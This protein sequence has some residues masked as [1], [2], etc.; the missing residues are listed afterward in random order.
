MTAVT[1]RGTFKKD[2]RPHNG[3]ESIAGEL[4]VDKIRQHH[5]VGIVKWAGA[6][7]SEDG[8]LTPAVK[9]L[10]IEPVSGEDAVLLGQILDRARS[11][12]GLPRAEEEFA[13]RVDPTL[14]DIDDDLDDD[15]PVTNASGEPVAPPSKDELDAEKAEA[16]QVPAAEFSGKA[17]A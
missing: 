5:I 12:R 1:I 10:A 4:T 8:T 13:K 16:A 9:F 11:R 15:E 7:V 17:D 6:N 14:F 2:S 3:L